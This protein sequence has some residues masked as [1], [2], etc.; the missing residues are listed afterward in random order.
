MKP[1]EKAPE[2]PPVTANETTIARGA[3]LFANTCAQCH[4]QQA[5]GG[6]KD[7]RKLTRETHAKF[8]EHRAWRHL[9]GQGHGEL[10]R[11]AEADEVDAIHAYII[12]RAQRGLG[13]HDG[14]HGAA[15]TR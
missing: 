9:Q 12:A 1:E 8:N 2:P 14:R 5:I 11:C 13:P 10:R 7:L 6:V 15:L 4:G 3:Q